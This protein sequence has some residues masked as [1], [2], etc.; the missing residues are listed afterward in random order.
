MAQTDKSK[1]AAE[2]TNVFFYCTDSPSAPN[3][4]VRYVAHEAT[5]GPDAL[6]LGGA[7]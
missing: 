4:S 1:A 6:L 7:Y 5:K 3:V 2:P